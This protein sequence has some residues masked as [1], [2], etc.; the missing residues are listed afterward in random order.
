M[1]LK[2]QRFGAS[3]FSKFYYTLQEK[4][5]ATPRTVV[6]WPKKSL[7]DRSQFHTFMLPLRFIKI[8]PFRQ[9]WISHNLL[10]MPRFQNFPEWIQNE[11]VAETC[12]FDGKEPLFSERAIVISKRVLGW[13]CSRGTDKDMLTQLFFFL[14]SSSVPRHRAHCCCP[15]RTPSTRRMASWG[16]VKKVPSP[17][18]RKGGFLVLGGLWWLTS[19][20][21]K[22]SFSYL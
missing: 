21:T 14:F 9:H 17:S 7:C 6:Y 3:S 10:S 8:R 22:K 19:K 5:F 13:E 18:S 11:K 2:S 16:A 20:Q 15:G 1:G 12:K 4:T